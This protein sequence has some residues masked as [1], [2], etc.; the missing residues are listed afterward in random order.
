MLQILKILIIPS[1]LVNM[2]PIGT[3]GFV[4]TY[5]ILIIGL[6][7]AIAV[8]ITSKANR[9]PFYHPFFAFL[10]FTTSI[11]WIYEIVNEIVNVLT[12]LGVVLSI[13]QT[14]LGLSILAFAN[15]VGGKFMSLCFII[16]YNISY[17]VNMCTLQ[18]FVIK[19]LRYETFDL[20]IAYYSW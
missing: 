1:L 16:F 9:P 12:T 19:L 8:A 15:S 13:P 20:H 11:F 4:V 6:L 17:I 2:N 10:G 14:I 3:E 7:V 18:A 5:L